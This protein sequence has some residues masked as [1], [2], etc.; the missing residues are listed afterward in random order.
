MAELG[1]IV[2]G[3]RD[4]PRA[5]DFWAAALDYELRDP[6]DDDW[7][8]LVPHDGREGTQLSLKLTNSDAAHRHHLDLFSDD[9]EAEVDRLLGLGAEP[10]DDWDY[11]P[12]ADY[13]VLRDPEGNPF[14]VV[15]V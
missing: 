3:V 7:A 12:D 14:C 8:V 15:Q 4:I 6:P 11:E 9:Q 1:S 5:I 2:W 13:V 10:V